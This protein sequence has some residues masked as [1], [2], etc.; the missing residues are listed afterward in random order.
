MLFRS[1]NAMEHT[2]YGRVSARINWWVNLELFEDDE[3]VHPYLV[4]VAKRCRR[5]EQRGVW[6]GARLW[7]GLCLRRFATMSVERSSRI[8]RKVVWIAPCGVTGPCLP[9]EGPPKHLSVHFLLLVGR[10]HGGLE[11]AALER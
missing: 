1:L 8:E 5:W 2:K 9:V 11:D 7:C 6:E 10:F 4:N 3:L